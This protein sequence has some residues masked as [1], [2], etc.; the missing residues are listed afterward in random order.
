MT[1]D[2]IRDDKLKNLM[3]DTMEYKAFNLGWA[4]GIYE[5][6]RYLKGYEGKELADKVFKEAILSSGI[7]GET[8]R[9]L[10]QSENVPSRKS[11]AF[12][13]KFR[14][15]KEEMEKKKNE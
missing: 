15:A 5:L 2:Q 14:M 3:E 4:C 11:E 6:Y 12:R 13:E 1:L 8:F 10:M 9:E 7:V